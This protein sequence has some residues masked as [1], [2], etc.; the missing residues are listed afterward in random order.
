MEDSDNTAG[1]SPKMLTMHGSCLDSHCCSHRP[2][3]CVSQDQ[4][5]YAAVTNEPKVS[6]DLKTL[7]LLVCSPYS[8]YMSITT[9]LGH[10]LLSVSWTW[11]E[12]GSTLMSPWLARQKNGMCW[13]NTF[14]PKASPWRWNVPLW[15]HFICHRKSRGHSQL[16]RKWRKAT[17]TWAWKTKNWGNLRYQW[18]LPQCLWSLACPTPL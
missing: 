14:A 10:G 2:D 17:P 3:V 9:W 4:T 1:W 12:G 7:F 13:N 18:C 6:V 16:Q 5:K 8:G 15:S 11:D